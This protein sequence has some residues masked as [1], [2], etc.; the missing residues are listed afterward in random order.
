[1]IL[2]REID[3]VRLKLSC[4]ENL[5]EAGTSVLELFRRL[6]SKQEV[7]GASVQGKL[8]EGAQIRF[9]WSLLKVMNEGGE[10][11]VGEPDFKRWPAEAWIPHVDTTLEVLTEQVRLLRRLG[12]QGEDAR[13]DQMLF[14]ARGA[15]ASGD[16]FLRRTGSRSEI[17]SG[18]VLGATADP[19]ALT[20]EDG[21]EAIY[22]AHL[23][24]DHRALLQG[25]NLPTDYIATFKGRAL[26][27]VFDPQGKPLL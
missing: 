11:C 9:G 8:R 6:Y 4:A 12:I 3:G 18:W 25:V 27:Q 17:D 14:V 19:E 16:V 21:L 24:G 10:L 22:L 1:M 15:L 20:Q 5:R 2:Q 7:A 23:V 13:F 26:E